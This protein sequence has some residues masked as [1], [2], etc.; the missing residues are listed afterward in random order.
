MA[1][2]PVSLGRS[3]MISE[4][5]VVRSERLLVRGRIVHVFVD[6]ADLAKHDIP[7]A[8]RREIASYLTGRR[9]TR[10]IPRPVVRRAAV[11]QSSASPDAKRL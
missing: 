11:P 6:P 9:P 8:V 4:F 2:G 10:R 7:E 3:S 5:E 1:V